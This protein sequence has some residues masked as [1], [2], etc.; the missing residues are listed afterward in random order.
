MTLSVLVAAG[1][2]LTACSG[3]TGPQGATGPTGPA[4]ATG[5]DGPHRPR[6]RPRRDGPHRRHRRHR[7]HRPTGPLAVSRR[8]LRLLPQPERRP[9]GVS[10]NQNLYHN[11]AGS[12]AL[13]K[14]SI[15]ITSVTWT[16]DTTT[17][18]SASRP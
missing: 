11:A 12:N 5:R 9:N 3:S 7:R 2:G 14:G 16:D 18:V 8:D 15:T 13:Y 10:V 4:G 1:I 6:R 17:P